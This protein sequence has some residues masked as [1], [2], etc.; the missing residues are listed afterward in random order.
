MS[1]PTN[2][3]RRPLE[4]ARVELARIALGEYRALPLDSL[5]DRD[6]T[7]WCGRFAVVIENLLEYVDRAPTGPQH[8]ATALLGKLLDLGDRE[9]LPVIEWEIATHGMLYGRCFHRDRSKRP[10][11]LRAWVEA[12]DMHPWPDVTNADGS[13][14]YHAVREDLDGVDVIVVADV[15]QEPGAGR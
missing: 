8:R 7:A 2:N 11:E 1:D 5:T 3:P 14:R 15:R 6:F 9:G 13:I 12:L 10:G 4:D